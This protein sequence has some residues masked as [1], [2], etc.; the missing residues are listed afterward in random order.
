MLNYVDYLFVVSGC[1]WL[2]M[3]MWEG[4]LGFLFSFSVFFFGSVFFRL[5]E[6]EGRLGIGGVGRGEKKEMGWFFFS[7]VCLVRVL[8]CFF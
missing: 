7:L 2:V 6:Y 8:V 1:L 4:K 3:E 5:V